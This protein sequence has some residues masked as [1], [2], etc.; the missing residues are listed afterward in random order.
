MY[1]SEWYNNLI[2]PPLSPPNWLFTPVW[3]ILY[4]L[5]LFALIL[6][7]LKES[8]N[9]KSGYIYYIIQIVLNFIWSPVFFGLKNIELAFFIIVLMDIFVILNIRKFYSIYKLSG[10]FLIPYLLWILFA[11]YL[12]GTYW[13]LN[14]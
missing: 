6:Y 11:T 7:I 4:I 13:I 5:I 2:Q 9:K 1:N 10:I 12:N 3:A 8:D 14:R